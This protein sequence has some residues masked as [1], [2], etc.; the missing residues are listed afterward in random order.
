MVN[1]ESETKT[2]PVGLRELVTRVIGWER[3]SSEIDQ[4]V[5]AIRAAMD[6]R[7]PLLLLGRDDMMSA[8]YTLHRHTVGVQH[9]F[10]ICNPRTETKRVTVRAPRSIASGVKAFWAARGGTLYLRHPFLPK[11]LPALMK[12]VRDPHAS[13]RLVVGL[14]EQPRPIVDLLGPVAVRVPMLHERQREISRIVSEY[15]ADARLALGAPASSFTDTD[16]AWV[17]AHAAKSFA[18]IEKATLRVVALNTS[19]NVS[20]AARLLGMQSVS[21]SRWMSRRSSRV[22]SGPWPRLVSGPRPSPKQLRARR[23][24]KIAERG[25]AFAT[26]GD[27]HEA[28]AVRT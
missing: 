22:L 11:D 9:P 4:A 1:I 8:A 16:Q 21:L 5:Y 10:V 7:A 27:R 14:D 12:L 3:K 13:V 6:C 17:V 25:Q 15:A 19:K 18:E 20:A 2:A 26:E 24:Q 28:K 23:R